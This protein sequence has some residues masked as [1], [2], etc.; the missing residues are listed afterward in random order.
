MEIEE[1]KEEFI[2]IWQT[3]FADD[4]LDPV[5]RSFKLE[6]I[7]KGMLKKKGILEDQQLLRSSAAGGGPLVLVVPISVLQKTDTPPD[8]F[9]PPRK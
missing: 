7:I 5:A 4:N 8:S 6:G 9:A 2:F 1:A 3:V